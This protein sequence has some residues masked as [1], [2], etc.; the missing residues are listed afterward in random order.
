MKAIR[1]HETG[2]PGVLTLEEVADPK[3]GAG[4]IL[5]RVKAVGV[6]PVETYKR[7]GAYGRLP[8]LPWI[9]GSDA[10]GVVQAVGTHADRFRPGDRVYTDHRATGA[11]AELL[12]CR[13][14]HAHALPD[15][16]SFAAG[17]AL[18]IPYATA[19]RA[20]FQRGEARPGESV[21]IHGG[22]GGVGLAAVQL[23]RAGGL[24]V[25]AT[26]GSD[27]GRAELLRQGAHHVLDHTH[28]AYLDRVGELTEGRGLDLVL[29]MLANVNLGRDLAI[30]A[31]RGRVIVVGSRGPVEINPRDAMSRDADI[32]AFTLFNAPPEEVDA[33]HSALREGLADQSLA[34]VVA[35]EFA[36]SDAP[37]AHEHVMAPGH[38]GKVVLIPG[39]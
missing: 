21:L 15:G 11:Y 28:S 23:A 26:G 33:I 17:A 24:T 19:F 3:P 7:A 10:A 39:E 31:T 2:G 20:L 5:V 12:T 34:P 35:A 27:A 4:E 30:L 36:L 22:T 6:N 18:G 29:E 1:V 8:D 16:V 25:I 32:R 13:E 37:R 9:P 14:G 38:R